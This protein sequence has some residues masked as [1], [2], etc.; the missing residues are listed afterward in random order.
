MDAF[1]PPSIRADSSLSGRFRAF[2][3]ALLTLALA[4]SLFSVPNP[5]NAKLDGSWQ[6]MLVHAHAHGIQFG[7]DLVFT[8][9]PW[10]FLCSLYHLGGEGAV[11]V[12]IWQTAGQL[13]V[14]MSLVFLTRR[15]VFWRRIAFAA[16]LL[17][18]HWLFLDVVYFVL[19]T[20]VVVSALMRRGEPVVRLVAWAL[21]LGFLAQIK[22]TYFALSAAG[23]LASAVCW[24]RR[25]SWGHALGV[26]GGYGVSVVA[27]WL[28]A[29]QNPGNLYA[30]LR[31][32][33]EIA[34]GYGD[35]MGM[36]ESWPV[37]IWGAGLALICAL[38]AWS[39]WR[40]LPERAFATSVAGFLAFALF[41]MW[42]ESFTRA[43]LVALGG[44]VFGLFTFVLILAPA[45]PGLLFPERR[46]HWFDGSFVYCL[47]GVACFDP[48]YYTQGPRVAW[49]R[50]YGN[51]MALAR[52]GTLPQEWQHAY[53]NACERASLPEMRA[54]VGRATVDVYDF[55]TGAAL[56]N[57]MN[58][59]SRPVFQGYSAYT[60][61]LEALN[62]LF[63]QSGREPD[64]LLW[65]D[66]RIDNRYPGQ[67]DAMLV[68]S[69]SGHYA[70]LFPEGEYW[71]F[72]RESPIPRAPVERRLLFK[73]TVRLSE[74]IELP[75]ERD[76]AIWLTADPV[77]DNLGRL[78]A[79]AYRP[80]EITIAVTDD[81]GG[82][83]VWR[84]LPRVAKGG[85]ILV[86]TLGSGGDM[87][88]LLR[89]EAHSWVRS[90]HFEAPQGQEEF[91]SHIDLGRLE[92]E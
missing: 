39:A 17:A 9:G 85:F 63:Y 52:L 65:N 53:E 56:L 19:I 33:L 42:K 54:T 57:R 86:P 50:I 44:H 69:L 30:Y 2:E 13:L 60:A 81:A 35:A 23:V 5:P 88:S 15:L 11:P 75:A 58:L 61:S 76:H 89:G 34:L 48:A 83:G 90:F 24:A 55:N 25:R 28:A 1:A 45:V 46:W 80:A 77:P 16:A 7:R 47:A 10:G 68:A 62:L 72:K 91:W 73:R 3:A 20:L 29:G 31:R 26:G 84:L 79:L 64:Y 22:F 40:T 71:L 32:S 67:D 49:E 87:A 51:V 82:R 21:L 4:L 70:P 18:S 38:F 6:E 8:W 37:F 14:A 78:R 12:L 41:L 43:D 74:E 27:A 36:D 66:E 59:D 92:M